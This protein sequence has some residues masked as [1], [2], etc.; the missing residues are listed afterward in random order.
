[1]LIRQRR[2][3]KTSRVNESFPELC[4][5]KTR[6]VELEA[7][8]FAAA[9][10]ES[11]GSVVVDGGY[12]PVLVDDIAVLFTLGARIYLSGTRPRCNAS[13]TLRIHDRVPNLEGA[14]TQL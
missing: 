5:A 12:R 4:G 3:G 10:D 13:L 9:C 11:D 14:H 8:D 7:V 1:M 6:I 2:S